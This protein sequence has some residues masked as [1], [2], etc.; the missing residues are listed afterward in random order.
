MPLEVRGVPTRNVVITDHQQ[1]L[2]DSLVESGRYQNVSEVLRAGLRLIEEHEA[3]DA[4]KLRLLRAA[5]QAGLDDIAAGRY[6]DIA[7]AADEQA[8]W[9]EI[10]TSVDARLSSHQ[11]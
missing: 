7:S 10:D 3:R 8:V 6:I 11:A 4:E 1:Q 9:T 2:I 5:V